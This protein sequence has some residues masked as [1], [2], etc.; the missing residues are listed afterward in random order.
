MK[1]RK[2]KRKLSKK[3]R[4]R[5]MLGTGFVAVITL[6]CFLIVSVLQFIVGSIHPTKYISC[7]SNTL[8]TSQYVKVGNELE[9]SYFTIVRG[10]KVSVKEVGELTS[11]VEY[12]GITLRIPNENLASSLKEVVEVDYVYPRRLVNLQKK[13]NGPLNDTVVTKGEKVKVVKVDEND[14]NPDTGIVDYYEVEKDGELYYLRGDYCETSSE[15]ANYNYGEDVNHSVYWDYYF[16]DGYSQDAYIDQI[17]YKPSVKVQYESNPIPETVNAMHVTLGY[18]LRDKEFYM[19]LNKKCGINAFILEVKNDSGSFYYDSDVAGKYL[20]KPEKAL[21]ETALT[22]DGLADLVQE[23]KDAGYYVIARMVT[24]KDAIFALQNED[25][26]ITETK[27]GSLYLH[28]D[29][30]WP[31]AY[32]R[33]AWMYN[34]DVAKELAQLGFN[35]IQFDY[36]RFPDG[37]LTDLLDG[38]I[39][40]KNTYNESKAAALQGFLMYAKEELKKYEVYVAADVFAWPVCAEDD[41]DTGQFFP[42]LANVCDVINPMPYLD[43]FSQGALGIENPQEAP[44]ETLY[45]FSKVVTQELQGITNPAIYRTWIQGYSLD[46]KGVQ[47]EIEGINKAGYSG[48]AVWY[49]H[50]EKDD[51]EPI[52]KGCIEGKLKN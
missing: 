37:T 32:S 35:E 23:L 40:L 42:A 29:E 16:G 22:K 30:Y 50:G 11:V 51:I 4:N 9:E 19:S 5:I 17:D 49:G 3:V 43:H 47:E 12:E 15:A 10:S 14:F 28:N 45:E 8:T 36:V 46:Y 38:N 24:F 33:K 13:R 27:D 34:C 52:L 18:F 6:T 21:T 20:D 31:S 48:Y 2:K 39:D 26:A 41:Q 25:D 1:K 44:G 7:P